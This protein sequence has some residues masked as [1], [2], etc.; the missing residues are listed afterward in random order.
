MGFRRN[1]ET[2]VVRS[3]DGTHPFASFALSAKPLLYV[4]LFGHGQTG[5]LPPE[6]NAYG[7]KAEID[8]WHQEGL[9]GGP[10]SQYGTSFR[11]HD[12]TLFS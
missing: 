4:R 11:R 3:G 2:R 1:D 8:R 7:R 10:V 6:V 9:D 12:D 5:V